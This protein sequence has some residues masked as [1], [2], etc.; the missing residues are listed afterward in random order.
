MS[1]LFNCYF[2]HF[3][4][5]ISS[6]A[7]NMGALQ[8][9]AWMWIVSRQTPLWIRINDILP[10]EWMV[11]TE[12]TG[13]D[14]KNNIYS[15][16][17]LIDGRRSHRKKWNVLKSFLI[18]SYQ[19]VTVFFTPSVSPVCVCKFRGA[20][21]TSHGDERKI[22]TSLCKISKAIWT[23]RNRTCERWT[24]YACVRQK[25]H[26]ADLNLPLPDK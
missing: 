25:F 26:M 17:M 14:A 16:K 11:S 8:R 18:D 21:W 13:D 10:S 3:S 4:T 2:Q 7:W 20:C 6:A 23:K 24:V 5:P 12:K 1:S 22:I 15:V 19:I 9:A